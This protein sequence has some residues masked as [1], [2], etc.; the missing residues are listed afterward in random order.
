M[1]IQALWVNP[2]SLHGWENA[3]YAHFILNAVP[4][5]SL[6]SV[7]MHLIL[8][9]DVQVAIISGVWCARKS[10][11]DLFPSRDCYGILGIEDS[12]SR[13]RRVGSRCVIEV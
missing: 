7:G 12:L 3:Q 9:L 1:C 4:L 10:S 11:G 8:D 13:T 6:D 5:Q 2:F